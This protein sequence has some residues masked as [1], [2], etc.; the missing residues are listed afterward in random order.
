MLADQ[1]RIHG[2]AFVD[3][4]AGSPNRDVCQQ[5]EVKWVEGTAP[6]S[7]AHPMHPNARG[8]HAV[9]SLTLDTLRIGD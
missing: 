9:A 4:Y 8:M 6:T 3:S 7:P 1:A 5:P 2:V